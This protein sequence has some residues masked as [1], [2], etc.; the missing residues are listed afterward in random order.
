MESQEHLQD[1]I[2]L[3]KKLSQEYKKRYSY[4]FSSLFQTYWNTTLIEEVDYFSSAVVLDLGCGNGILLKDLV[5]KF[6]CAVGVDASLDMVKDIKPQYG[7]NIN[8]VVGDGMNLPVL[9]ESFD[10]VICRGTL[11]HLSSLT[12]GLEEIQR[13]LK[14]DGILIFSEPS[15]DSPLVRAARFIMYKFSSKFHEDDI[16]FYEKEVIKIVEKTGF[17]VENTRRFGFFAY[18]LLGFPDHFPLLKY[19]PFNVQLSKALIALDKLFARLPFV[20]NQSLHL[21]VKARR[22]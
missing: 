11:H 10:I 3:H 14:K 2:E 16:A 6:K 1:E 20:K 13:C 17:R 15:N 19:I 12:Q 7:P 22:T 4:K 5:K 18:V 9:A 8:L 21:I